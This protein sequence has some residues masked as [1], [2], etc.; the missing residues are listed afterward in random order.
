MLN[1]NI[2]N[3][4]NVS[5][6]RGSTSSTQLGII[7]TASNFPTIAEAN[8]SVGQGYYLIAADVTDNDPT[9]TNTGQSFTEGQQVFW[10]GEDAYV[11]GSFQLPIASSTTLGGIKVGAN[12]TIDPITG[13]LSANA[14]T[15]V[16]IATIPLNSGLN[17]IDLTAIEE[18]VINFVVGTGPAPRT[19]NSLI[20]TAGQ[21][22]LLV[23]A[24]GL[25]INSGPSLKVQGDAPIDTALGDSAIASG[26]SLGAGEINAYFKI[27]G[28]AVTPSPIPL[29]APNI[30]GGS[31]LAKNTGLVDDNQEYYP[32]L[33]I[34]EDT[35]SGPFD[36]ILLSKTSAWIRYLSPFTLADLNYKLPDAFSALG[37]DFQGVT[38]KIVNLSSSNK[39]IVKLN[40]DTEL[41]SV[42]PKQAAL[43]TL[44]DASTLDGVWQVDI[45]NSSVK[46]NFD[47]AVAPSYSDDSTLGYSIGSN[48]Y[49]LA[50]S[51]LYTC[52]DNAATSALWVK[53]YPQNLAT[54][55]I[56]IS[57]TPYSVSPAQS[58]Y[59]F[60]NGSM[61]SDLVINLPAATSRSLNFKFA[62]TNSSYKITL[63]PNGSDAIASGSNNL[64]SLE[65]AG[66]GSLV[67]LQSFKDGQYTSQF[68]GGSLKNI[69]ALEFAGA[70][71]RIKG[72]FSGTPYSDR[73]IF[74]SN[75]PIADFT[76]VGAKPKNANN[77][78]GWVCY[79]K[80]DVDNASFIIMRAS[81]SNT[82]ILSSKNGTGEV[83]PC[84]IR[85]DDQ[86][87]A[88]FKTDGSTETQSL[89]IAGSGKTLKGNF[90][91]PILANKTFI[92]SNYGDGDTYVP[93]AP[94]LP[95][96]Y[97]GVQYF[98]DPDISNCHAVG[99][100]TSA[101][102]YNFLLS[103][104]GAGTIKPFRI[105]DSNGV[106]SKVYLQTDPSD[107]SIKIT[108]LKQ[109]EFADD[110]TNMLYF[111]PYVTITAAQ[112][113]AG[114]NLLPALD[115]GKQYVICD[116][117]VNGVGLTTIATGDPFIY[118][119]NSASPFGVAFVDCS[120]P[121][122]AINK[123]MALNTPGFY[124]QGSSALQAGLGDSNPLIVRSSAGL[125][126]TGSVF[127]NVTYK[128]INS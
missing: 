101:A 46:N 52:L 96:G 39:A 43:I 92:V 83:V 32:L 64:T 86:I 84:R 74:E 117:S 8:A 60:T 110:N 35:S 65:V 69:S 18:P 125:M 22:K 93:L 128:I 44:L 3:G 77:D 7:F 58:N 40:S 13:A 126:A 51:E 119:G 37:A 41:C 63:V 115:F 2:L 49:N 33:Q 14:G 6:S 12:L 122:Y 111:K 55:T 116:L 87:N 5:N 123:G 10:N 34:S 95:G 88:L 42:N 36:E 17:N 102:Y 61:L 81:L 97:C 76:Y 23:F 27:D 9:K 28:T 45:V 26:N 100:Y 103:S 71:R 38:F 62:A 1:A 59:T 114:Y 124:A 50:D 90:G 120:K 56:S 104:F 30:I 67:S 16:G 66:V 19:L 109:S 25:R 108:K 91:D 75:D 107:G 89:S 99:F 15:Q 79:N 82:E 85:V 105:I 98:S 54:P 72:K 127:I 78:S 94:Q 106:S 21:Q 48:W 29:T 73:T 53:I 70:G 4:G 118:F 121:E 113:N 112:L 20:M 47:A 80:D 57:S 68:Q 24:N 11:V 31:K